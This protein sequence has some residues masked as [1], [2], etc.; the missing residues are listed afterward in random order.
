M[1]S[2]RVEQGHGARGPGAF[3]PNLL[4]SRRF[5]ALLWVATVLLFASSLTLPYLDHDALLYALIGHGIAR[6]GVLPYSYAFD[7]K[8]ALLYLF[9]APL[10]LVGRNWFEFQFFSLGGVMVL[11]AVTWRLFIARAFG[12]AVPL[13]LIAYAAYGTVQ[14]SGNSEYVFVPLALVAVALATRSAGSPGRL[15]ASAVCAAIA[16]NSNYAGGVALAVPVLVCL[17]RT[18]RSPGELAG[19]AGLYLAVMAAL[20]LAVLTALALGGSDPGAYLGLQLRFLRG[21][22]GHAVPV[23]PGVLAKLIG[24]LAVASLALIAR[25]REPDVYRSDVTVDLALYALVAGSAAF[26]V[27][28]GKP[29]PHLAFV[30]A[31]PSVILLLRWAARDAF[32]RGVTG[33][34]CAAM[35][36][37][38][39]YAFTSAH[40]GHA[41]DRQA[42]AQPYRAIADLVGDRSLLSMR[43]SVVPL[44]YSGARPFQPIV[45]PEQTGLLF[46][47]NEDRYFLRQ[48]ARRPAFVMTA[49]DWCGSDAPSWSSCRVVARDY[50]RMLR[51]PG[52]GPAQSG[53]RLQVGYDLYRAAPGLR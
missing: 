31:V 6:E 1:T 17:W 11:A 10:A 7:H 12:L 32:A 39:A 24:F 5:G 4:G 34:L 2:E 35:G 15:A 52:E 20:T 36:A 27:L 50:R 28:S 25:L 33:V 46:G 51:F 9:Y 22:G 19:R 3:L 49:P 21:Y 38:A 26:M 42:F 18:S 41:Y 47:R 45:W 48:L 8:P 44:Y 14:F 16:A 29:W 40:A 37:H 13:I 53:D 30:P 23:E 43:A